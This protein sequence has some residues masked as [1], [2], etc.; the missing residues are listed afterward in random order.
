MEKLTSK[1]VCDILGIS[2]PTLSRYRKAGKI[3]YYKLNS[4]GA[5]AKVFYLKKDIERFLQSCRHN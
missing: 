5:T 2:Y 1:Q 3:T 4:G